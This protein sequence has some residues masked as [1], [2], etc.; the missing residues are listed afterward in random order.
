MRL[1]EA[2]AHPEHPLYI[3]ASIFGPRAETC[4]AH[5]RKGSL[6]AVAGRLRFREWKGVDLSRRSEHSLT[7]E[8]ID[9]LSAP[10]ARG[11]EQEPAEPPGAPAVGPAAPTPQ[12]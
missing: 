3:D 5:L 6:V 1:A 8:R 7:A 4:L 11:R 9:F 2:G 10:A 12:A